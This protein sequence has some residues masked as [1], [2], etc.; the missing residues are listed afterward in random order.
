[1][2]K[3][4]PLNTQKRQVVSIV[5][6]NK[7]DLTEHNLCAQDPPPKKQLQ[8]TPEDRANKLKKMT[9]ELLKNHQRIKGSSRCI[10]YNAAHNQFKVIVKHTHVGTFQTLDE[11]EKRLRDVKRAGIKYFQKQVVN[12]L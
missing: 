1:M 12:E 8:Q 4:P 5:N 2:G 9:A 7:Y 3:K 6:G 10:L 11:A